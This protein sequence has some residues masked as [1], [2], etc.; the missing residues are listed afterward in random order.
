M[1]MTTFAERT[2]INALTHDE[3]VLHARKTYAEKSYFQ[4]LFNKDYLE[5]SCHHHA[6]NLRNEILRLLVVREVLQR[7]VNLEDIHLHIP[8]ELKDYNFD[9]GVNK[10]STY[11]Y[12]T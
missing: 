1:T 2:N 11:L 12:E 6:E 10:L 3:Y 9:D 7:P 5:F 4:K 8:Q